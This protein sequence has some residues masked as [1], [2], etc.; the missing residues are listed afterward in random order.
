MKQSAAVEEAYYIVPAVKIT[1]EK[2][3]ELT[4][5]YGPEWRIDSHRVQG[6]P[7]D[8]ANGKNTIVDTMWL[9][10]VK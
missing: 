8:V 1:E 4:E 2:A 6:C 5:R 9:E 7:F 3:S 10:K